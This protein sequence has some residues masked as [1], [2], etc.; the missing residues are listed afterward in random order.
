MVHIGF[1]HKPDSGLENLTQVFA[2]SLYEKLFDP[3][4]HWLTTDDF[5]MSEHFL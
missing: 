2:A 3:G 4:Q 5:V 1:E